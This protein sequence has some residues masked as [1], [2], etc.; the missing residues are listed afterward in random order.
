[1]QANDMPNPP[2]LAEWCYSAACLLHRKNPALTTVALA[3]F[4]QAPDVLAE[5][6]A[7]RTTCPPTVRAA[8]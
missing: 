3:M 2:T 4:A 8:A 5:E 7:A 6:E 1:M